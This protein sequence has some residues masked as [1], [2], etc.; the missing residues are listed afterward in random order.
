[1]PWWSSLDRGEIEAIALALDLSARSVLL[2]DRLAR[3]AAY[4]V[5]LNVVGSVGVLLEAHRRGLIGTVRPDLHAMV[6]AGFRLSRPLYLEIL[7]TAEEH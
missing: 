7:A 2:D 6:E 3:R 5:G 1:M 4:Q